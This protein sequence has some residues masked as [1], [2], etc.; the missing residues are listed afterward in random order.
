MTSYS[1]AHL[2]QSCCAGVALSY[3]HCPSL[4]AGTLSPC[5][6]IDP[7]WPPSAS[8][9]FWWQTLSSPFKHLDYIMQR[10]AFSGVA[11]SESPSIYLEFTSLADS[12][13]AVELHA[14]DLYKLLKTDL[15]HRDWSGSAAD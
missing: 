4:L 12:I 8:F 15:F 14:F 6:Y 9:R 3:R 7:G 1:A 2:L 13:V 5:I 11:P 10:R